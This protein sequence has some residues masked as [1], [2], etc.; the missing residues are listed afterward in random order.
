M[1]LYRLCASLLEEPG[2]GRLVGE[3]EPAR[4]PL[5]R[6]LQRHLDPRVRTQLLLLHL[7]LA[8]VVENL[9]H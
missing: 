7:A 4:V 6:E 3:P 1:M 9:V 2:H 5:L 8:V